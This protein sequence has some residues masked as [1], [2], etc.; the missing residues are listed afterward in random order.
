MADLYRKSS[1]ERLSNPEQL[2]KRITITSPMSKLMLLGVVI[3]IVA[4]IVWSIV[5]TLPTTCTVNGMIVAPDSACAF[6]TDCAGTVVEITKKAGDSV[7]KNEAIAVVQSTD[8]KKNTIRATDNGTVSD[9]LI[10]V[11]TKIYPGAEIMRYTPKTSNSQIVVCYVPLMQAQQLENDMEVLV[12]L[13]NVDSQKYGHMI[14]TIKTVGEYAA[15]TNN[16]WYVLGANNLVGEQFLSVGPVVSVICEI[17]PDATTKSG[18]HWT[19]NNGK[20]L[21]VSNGSF[22]SAKIVTSECAPITK[23]FNG[24]KDK[25][26]VE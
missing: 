25:L 18:Y 5:G 20:A 1:I 6:Y 3:I 14:A 22:V 16:M 10:D 2:D 12:Y 26:G 11:D 21:S 19:N 7:V 4:T 17:E 24:L 13:T 15:A 9:V 23:L 8:G